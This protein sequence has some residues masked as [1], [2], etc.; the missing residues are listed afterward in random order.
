M[1][2]K[3]VKIKEKTK[4][5]LKT[6]TRYSLVIQNNYQKDTFLNGMNNGRFMDIELKTFKKRDG[7]TCKFRQD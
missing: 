1:R 5:N 4:N 7:A 2:I 6:S 3:T